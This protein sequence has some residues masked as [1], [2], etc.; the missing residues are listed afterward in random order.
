MIKNYFKLKLKLLIIYKIIIF[1]YYVII[2]IQ[3]TQ[4]E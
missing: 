3:H 4:Y 1:R 2:I